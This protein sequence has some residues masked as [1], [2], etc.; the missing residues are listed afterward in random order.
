M[1]GFDASGACISRFMFRCGLEPLPLP[2]PSRPL[3]SRRG[4]RRRVIRCRGRRCV[5]H[6]GSES[7]LYPNFSLTALSLVSSQCRRGALRSAHP[8]GVGVVISRCTTKHFPP[9]CRPKGYFSGV[10]P[11]PPPTFP[12]LLEELLDQSDHG[13]AGVVSIMACLS[14]RPRISSL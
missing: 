4:P 6:P 1:L 8:S 11:S 7:D 13:A 5:P 14:V 10:R 3:S 9:H 2:P 12:F